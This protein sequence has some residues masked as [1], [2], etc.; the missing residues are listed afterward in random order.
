MFSYEAAGSFH[1]PF[2]DCPEGFQTVG[3][4]EGDTEILLQNHAEA[5]P[6]SERIGDLNRWRFYGLGERGERTLCTVMAPSPGAQ[7]SNTIS[8]VV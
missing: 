7:P 1:T 2:S 8:P 4:F 5:D 6:S 3:I